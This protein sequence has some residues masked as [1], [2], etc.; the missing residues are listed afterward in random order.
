MRSETSPIRRFA[1]IVGAPRCGTTF[2]ARHLEKHS[3]ICFSNV[4]EPH[5]FSGT[6]LR[7]VPATEFK[8]TVERDYL[9]RFFPHRSRSP[10]LAEGSVT[11]LYTPEQVKPLLRLWPDAKFIIAVRNPL[12]MVPSL[13]RR[14]LCIGDA[15]HAMSPVGGVGINLAVQDAVAAANRLADPL[16]RRAVTDAD[17]EAVERRRALP[18]RLTQWLQIFVQNRVIGP[19]LARQDKVSAP[20]V[21]KLI[22]RWP[23]LRRIPGRLVGLGVL[24][25]HVRTPDVGTAT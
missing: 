16:R 21:V 1:F 9:D 3:G 25:E 19:T 8:R 20:A 14:L 24:P 6:D 12:E 23:A 10:F 17:L 7:G 18:V 22:N 5:F 13:H 4:K 11:Y 15:A 2:L